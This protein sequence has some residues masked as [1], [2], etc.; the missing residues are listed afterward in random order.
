MSN[1]G[2]VVSYRRSGDAIDE[3]TKLKLNTR[4]RRPGRTL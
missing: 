2:Q 3:L 4:Q 1:T